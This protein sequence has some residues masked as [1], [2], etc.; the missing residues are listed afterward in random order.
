MRLAHFLLF[1]FSVTFS[2]AQL[3]QKHLR[4]SSY[5]SA[6]VAEQSVDTLLLPFWDDFSTS[7]YSVDST[8]WMYGIDVFVNPTLGINPPTINVASFDGVRGDGTP[9]NS[10]SNTPQKGDSLVSKPINLAL[11]SVQNRSTVY[12]SFF[13]QVKGIAELPDE[14]DSFSLLFFNKQKQWVTVWKMQ[15]GRENAKETF[16]QEII[17]ILQDQFFH[18]G[19]AFKFQLLGN[20]TGP[21][22]SWHVDY[23]LL[24]QRRDDNSITRLGNYPKERGSYFDRAISTAP[25]SPFKGYYGIPIKQ[26]KS[27][28]QYYAGVSSTQVYNLN[29]VY[30][31]LNYNVWV[32]QKNTQA[33]IKQLNTNTEIQ[34]PVLYGKTFRNILSD[35]LNPKL[36]LPL[37]DTGALVM[38]LKT[39]IVSGDIPLIDDINPLTAD[40]SF[41]QNVDFRRNDTSSI[42]LS[43]SD[44]IAQDDGIAEYAVGRNQTKGLLALKFYIPTGDSLIGM[45]IYFPQI[46]PIPEKQALDILAWYSIADKFPVAS[47][48]ITVSFP[49]ELN[50]FKRFRFEKAIY[51]ADTFYIGYK[52]YTNNWIGIGLDKNNDNGKNIYYN[53]GQAW[54]QNTIV[55]GTMMIRPVFARYSE[56]R[57]Q[58]VNRQN[59]ILNTSRNAESPLIL[60]PNPTKDFI[61]F[62]QEPQSIS[63]YNIYGQYIVP[64]IEREQGIYRVD[65]QNIQKGI[66]FIQYIINNTIYT[67]KTILIAE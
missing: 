7:S 61:Y 20:S 57:N 15:G 38:Q 63:I 25:T 52:Q 47:Q 56:Q 28:P 21:F 42:T 17:P 48:R 18:Q 59:V 40:T 9:H 66:Y 60:Y 55:K 58:N 10:G 26:L 64:K 34:N 51:V 6:R 30:Q 33:L 19:F 4:S 5:S 29:S 8:L 46:P 54:E 36:L 35:T 43:L 12:F 2:Y 13:W 45:D 31:P 14:T 23:I 27:T 32:S 53:N 11:V 49:K 16:T 39:S 1:F 37:I 3:E 67:Q 22:D 62:S 24:N 41:A 50:T 65:L 44:F